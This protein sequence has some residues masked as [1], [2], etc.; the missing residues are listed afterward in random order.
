MQ[1]KTPNEYLFPSYLMLNFEY[2]PLIF[3]FN[4]LGHDAFNAHV[5]YATIQPLQNTILGIQLYET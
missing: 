1:T 5:F 4:N 2:L 3:I